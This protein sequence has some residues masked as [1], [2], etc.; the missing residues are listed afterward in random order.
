MLR[1]GEGCSGTAGREG[2]LGPAS[3]SACP[4]FPSSGRCLPQLGPQGSW[5]P[6]AGV[7]PHS[8]CGRWRAL[9]SLV[10]VTGGAP[11]QSGAGGRSAW[12][13]SQVGA[14][15]EP[16]GPA[17]THPHSAHTGPTP[18]ARGLVSWGWG[19]TLF[20]HQGQGRARS[21]SWSYFF[22]VRKRRWKEAQ[23]R[24]GPLARNL[25]QS[26]VWAR[27]GERGLAPPAGLHGAE[28]PCRGSWWGEEGPAA[29][30][31]WG[32]W[33]SD[34]GEGLRGVWALRVLCRS[35]T[36]GSVSPWGR[37]PS[38]PPSVCQSGRSGRCWPRPPPSES[39]KCL[40]VRGAVEW[41]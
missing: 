40:Q 4:M 19:E 22:T 32:R 1:E 35:Q 8:L 17:G 34:V 24:E 2:R 33:C 7:H 29:A 14:R 11:S 18:A 16:S 28:G 36:R 31:G 26:Q 12:A 15:L 27:A 6:P 3:P 23:T 37:G 20:P 39:W 5:A 25:S 13:R 41:E 21:W 9:G 30:G 38:L 10:R